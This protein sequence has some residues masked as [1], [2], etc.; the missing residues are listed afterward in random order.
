MA[1][2][3]QDTFFD[4]TALIEHPAVRVVL[5][6]H[7]SHR[8]G[9]VMPIAEITELAESH[10]ADVIVDAAH[11]WGQIPF[12]L[13]DLAAPFI[14][15]NLHK[16]MGA[17]LGCGAT[18]VRKDQLGDIDRDL[19]DEDYDASDI[20][21]RVH[22]G[23]SNSANYLAVPA[24]LDVH[25]ALGAD[26]KRARV[27]YLRDLWVNEVSGLDRMHILTPDD[28]SMYG[29]LTA[30]RIE[31]NTTTEQSTA[32]A[33]WLRDEKGILT[34]RRGGVDKGEVI[35]VTVAPW[36]SPDQCEQLASALGEAVRLF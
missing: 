34:V 28:P 11:S 19:A 24:A 21:S 14:G 22:T 2:S 12:E 26:A 18:Y 3:V 4:K 10:G 13:P 30:F 8:T 35:R 17:P 36:T 33:S 32:I 5:T 1:N 31:G 6:T 15:L 27:Q 16:W 20:R 7:L 29:A 23:T 25:E 9:L